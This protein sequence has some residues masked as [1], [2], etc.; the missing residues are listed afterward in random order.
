MNEKG[1]T[2]RKVKVRKH[3]LH[4]K[5]VENRAKH[6]QDY[7]EAVEGYCQQGSE[8]LSTRRTKVF[9]EIS[10]YISDLESGNAVD[11][12]TF[13]VSLDLKK[14]KS[15][16]KVYD[17]I[18]MMVEMSVDDEIELDTHEFACYV[19]DDWDWKDEFSATTASYLSKKLP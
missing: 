18:I 5:L 8:L 10:L 4:S 17:Q 11:P 2:M 13:D 6:V 19:M 3:E 15:Y 9:D 12:K 7:R 14:P 16:E 1:L